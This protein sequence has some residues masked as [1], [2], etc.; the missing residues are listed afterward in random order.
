LRKLNL[1]DLINKGY[2]VYAPGV[3]QRFAL[4]LARYMKR[5]AY[6]SL[7]A[8]TAPA[9]KRIAVLL[10][11]ED[12][13]SD[14][15]SCR[16]TKPYAVLWCNMASHEGV[17]L[18]AG[19]IIRNYKR[20]G[21][22]KINVRPVG[23]NLYLVEVTL[24]DSLIREYAS[25]TEDYSLVPAEN[26]CTHDDAYNVLSQWTGISKISLKEAVEIVSLGLGVSKSEARRRVA[27]LAEKGCIDIIDSKT[28]ILL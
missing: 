15:D 5:F 19:T 7:T 25:I 11:G 1:L 17:V 18:V 21:L 8:C 28:V 2:R 14:C 10:L 26:P 27:Q 23:N 20:L 24:E 13:V 16:T 12:S 22:L 4:A 9:L 3:P 6:S